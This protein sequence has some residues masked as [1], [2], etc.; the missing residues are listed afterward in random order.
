MVQ[1]LY[2]VRRR[3]FWS[4]LFSDTHHDIQSLEIEKHGAEFSPSCKVCGCRG[5]RMTRS[6]LMV[7]E[8]LEKDG[9]TLLSFGKMV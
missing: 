9:V 6:F 7:S 4:L 8:G 1:I 3:V 5:M 2:S